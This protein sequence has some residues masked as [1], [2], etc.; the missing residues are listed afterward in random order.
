MYLANANYGYEPGWAVGSLQMAE[1]V[2]AAEFALEGSM[3]Q[4]GR[5]SHK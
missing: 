2:L 5:C 3:S 4:V 1:T